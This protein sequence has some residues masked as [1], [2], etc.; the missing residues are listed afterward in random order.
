MGYML[1]LQIGEFTKE[2]MNRREAKQLFTTP[3][4]LFRFVTPAGSASG[5]A[6]VLSNTVWNNTVWNNTVWKKTF[7]SF[8]PEH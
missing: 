7:Q 4:P 5:E 3:R 6:S 1:Q 2:G 8:I